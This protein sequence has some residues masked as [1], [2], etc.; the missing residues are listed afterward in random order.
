M[1]LDYFPQRLPEF[2]LVPQSAA[3]NGSSVKVQAFKPIN[4]K[5]GDAVKENS[6]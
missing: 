3:I 6:S 4:L 5:K 2:D 1:K